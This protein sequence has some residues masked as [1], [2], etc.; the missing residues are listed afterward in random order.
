MSDF[1]VEQTYD[2]IQSYV[3]EAA[4]SVL[5]R[6]GEHEPPLSAWEDAHYEKQAKLIAMQAVL[7][8]DAAEEAA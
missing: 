6:Q 5:T 4:L 3:Y 1:R 7:H 2:E 8:L